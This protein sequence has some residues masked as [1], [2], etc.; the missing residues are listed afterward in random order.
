M[1]WCSLGQF[2]GPAGRFC[3][4]WQGPGWCPWREIGARRTVGGRSP[5]QP[6]RRCTKLAGSWPP[7]SCS[8]R[9]AALGRL[10]LICC[11]P[12]APLPS[13]CHHCRER[14]A[15]RRLWSGP[16]W[17]QQ[18]ETQMGRAETENRERRRNVGG[19]VGKEEMY[20]GTEA[21]AYQDRG[22]HENG[23]LDTNQ[24]ERNWRMARL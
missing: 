2:P 17:V 10:L 6:A 8:R 14:V 12:I 9:S 5:Q 15:G 22:G 24:T 13:R 1:R 3:G 7:R 11:R 16:S 21:C 18:G 4:A 20:S 19:E 23:P